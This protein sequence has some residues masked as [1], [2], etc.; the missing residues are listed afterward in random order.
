MSQSLNP[1]SASPPVLPSTLL[2]Y[3]SKFLTAPMMNPNPAPPRLGSPLD[4]DPS[5]KSPESCAYGA[6]VVPVVLCAT[7]KKI[8]TSTQNTPHI[9]H[10][11]HNGVRS[12]RYKHGFATS[13]TTSLRQTAS[14]HRGPSRQWRTIMFQPPKAS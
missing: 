8:V 11:N 6:C 4:W 14:I 5:E 9:T 10:D 1:L 13:T 12:S 2:L 7:T 3:P